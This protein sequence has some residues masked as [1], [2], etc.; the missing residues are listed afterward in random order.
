M[1]SVALIFSARIPSD[2]L[3][4]LP[5]L[6]LE[7]LKT[8]DARALL[9]T[10]LAGPVDSRVW[11]EI[12]AET[13]GNPLAILELPRGLTPT[14][15]AGGFGLAGALSLS[16]TIEETFG[17][18]ISSLPS[19]S[20][21]LLLLAAAEPLGEPVL[22]WQA[23]DLLGIVRSAANAAIDAELIVFDAR[24]HFRHPLVRSAVYYSASTGDRQEAHRALAAVTDPLRDPDRRAWHRAEA[25]TGP[26]ED[27]AEELER[28]ANRAQAR[29][30]Y[31]ATSAFLERSAVL[32]LNP[33]RRSARALAAAR[34]KVQARALTAGLEL[35]SIAEAGPLDEFERAHADLVRAQIAFIGRR[36]REAPQL[37]LDAAKQLEPFDSDLA[38]STYADAML[39]AGHAGRFAAPGGS[40]LEVARQVM[41]TSTD[42]PAALDLL[43]GG[44][45]ANV[46]QGYASSCPILRNALNAFCSEMPEGQERRGLRL[47]LLVSLQLWDDD[48]CEAIS[49]RWVKSSRDAGAFSD[50]LVALTIRSLVLLFEGNTSEA[51]SLI[52]EVQT[53]SDAIGVDFGPL[54]E[55][56][57][58]AFRGDEAR[59][60][61]LIDANV[62]KAQGRGEGRRVAMAMWASAVLNNGL[63][64]Y[65]DA[66]VAAQRAT[67]DPFETIYPLWALPEL[68]EA[69]VRSGSSAVAA[70]AHRRLAEMADASA[71]DWALG[72]AARSRA[73]LAE[74]EEAEP[75]FWEAIEH[76]G[77]TRM[78]SELA[79][80]RLL[81]GEWLRRQ[82]RRSDARDQLRRAIEMFE[83]MGMDGFSDRARRELRATGERARKRSPETK[84][85]LTAQESQIAKLARDGMSNPEIGARLFISTRTVE[86]HLSKVFTKLDI[87]SRVQLERVLT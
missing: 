64:R 40:M 61:H 58:A 68:I 78:R 48:V 73:L 60:S 11:E 80:A 14:Q 1:E 77:R 41:A 79:R 27:V 69:A 55:L 15:L 86:Y 8:H 85:E 87:T 75:S 44:L 84:S 10:V 83:A 28:S 35:V 6:V 70:D 9:E 20:R 62:D 50:L 26:D 43:L 37:L 63:G 54:G 57:L 22:V 7:V 74:D 32:T 33:A 34:A 4:G 76:L 42:S 12:L 13:G 53:V 24:V 82:R 18:R 3:S 47:A 36:G 25:S 17:Q 19:D 31:A 49:E 23:A 52:E 46:I 30:G 21:R 71:S 2:E 59:T 29:G 81:Y 51:T 67:E 45:A 66:L 16:G 72:L 56:G 65:Q 5:Q 38:R 39:A